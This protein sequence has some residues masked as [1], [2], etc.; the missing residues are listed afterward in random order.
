[1]GNKIAKTEKSTNNEK[2]KQATHLKTE[3]KTN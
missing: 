1:M 2:H 3:W